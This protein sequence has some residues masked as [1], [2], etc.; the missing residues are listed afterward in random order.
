MNR[1]MKLKQFLTMMITTALVRKTS[2]K[3]FMLYQ[4][5]IKALEGW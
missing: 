1:F 5:R 3:Q 4:T 2:W